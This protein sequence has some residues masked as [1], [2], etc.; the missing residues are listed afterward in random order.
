MQS[1]QFKIF[2]RVITCNKYLY[3]IHAQDSSECNYCDGQQD[4]QVHFFVDCPKATHFWK[5]IFRW[6]NTTVKIPTENITECNLILGLHEKSSINDILNLVLL[7]CKFYIYRQRL[8]HKC[9]LC[10]LQLLLELKN[11]LLSEQYICKR[12]NK[13]KSFKKRQ[14][15]LEAL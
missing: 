14:K 13:L 5:S 9:D 1:F 8:F 6:L 11:H 15:V 3:N 7:R 4:T 2:Q 10:I 12:D